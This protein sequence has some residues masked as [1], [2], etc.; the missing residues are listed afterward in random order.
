MNFRRIHLHD[1]R[2]DTH[3]LWDSSAFEPGIRRPWSVWR[4][5]NNRAEAIHIARCT[6]NGYTGAQLAIVDST[7]VDAL[8]DSGA[9][10]AQAVSAHLRTLAASVAI[11]TPP[12][13]VSQGWDA[14]D[15]IA[16]GFDDEETVNMTKG[17]NR[18]GGAP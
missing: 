15:A 18:V 4:I 5:V 8:P 11:A 9:D 10:Y 12:A 6:F 2:S 14:V 17:N 16:E 3:Q 7:E 1:L 13:G